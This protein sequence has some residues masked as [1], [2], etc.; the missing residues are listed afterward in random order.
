MIENISDVIVIMDADGITKYQ[1][2]NIEKWFGWKPEDLVG[3]S[4]WDKMHPEDIERIQKEFGKML[5]KE[6]AS[7]VEYQI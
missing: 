6:T 4:G 7:I 3:T 2:P 5:E 1:S